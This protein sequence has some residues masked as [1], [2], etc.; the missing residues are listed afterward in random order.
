ML[1]VLMI[2]K[3]F[4]EG[5]GLAYSS[6]A[7]GTGCEVKQLIIHGFAMLSVRA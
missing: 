2:K 7:L 4:N 3:S 6:F 1:S 5:M